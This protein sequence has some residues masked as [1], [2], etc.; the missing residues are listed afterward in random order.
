[1]ST[2]LCHDRLRG[3]KGD[4]IVLSSVPSANL[5]KVLKLADHSES[6]ID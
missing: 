3:P 1:M 6:Y 4:L 2:L 5:V